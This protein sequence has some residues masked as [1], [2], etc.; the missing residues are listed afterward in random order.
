[1]FEK[2]EGNHI[3]VICITRTIGGREELLIDYILKGV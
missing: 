3:V 2:N 1:M